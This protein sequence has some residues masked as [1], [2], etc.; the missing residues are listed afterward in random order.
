MLIP[1]GA[2]TGE[3]WKLHFNV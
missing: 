3:L 1:E 2:D